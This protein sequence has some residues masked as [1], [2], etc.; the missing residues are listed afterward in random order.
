MIQSIFERLKY[1]L[2]ITLITLGVIFI[3]YIGLR[4]WGWYELNYICKPKIEESLKK[5]IIEV[6]KKDYGS[7]TDKSMF[8]SYEEYHAN[9]FQLGDRS[10]FF[11]YCK[12][13]FSHYYCI[14][15]EEWS[16][17][18]ADYLVEFKDGTRFWFTLFPSNG[19][20][21]S[22]EYEILLLLPEECPT[23]CIHPMESKDSKCNTID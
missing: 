5:F 8:E 2:K 4:L 14:I 7:L 15:K 12:R 6:I 16:Y 22:G 13:S 17:P 23:N 9:R 11:E 19:S 10:R 21:V 18:G 1:L 3:G 20:C